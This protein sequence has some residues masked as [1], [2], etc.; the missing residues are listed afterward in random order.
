MRILRNGLAI[1]F[2]LLLVS[3]RP[4]VA[5]DV[6]ILSGQSNMQKIG[7]SA[8]RALERIAE[9]NDRSF[10]PIYVAAPG[11]P[12]EAWLDSKH[13]DHQ[14]WLSLVEQVNK[15]KSGDNEFKG[16]VWYQGESNVGR[17]AGKYQIQLDTLVKRVRH[18][19]GKPDL[20]AI[21]VQIG[22]ATSYSGKDWAAGT[23]REAQRRFARDDKRAAVVAAIDAEIGDYTVHLS[24]AGAELVSAR[25]AAA[26]DRLAYGN[27]SAFWGPQFKQAF[28]L[29]QRQFEVLVEFDNVRAEL[30]LGDGWLAGFGV[31]TKTSLPDTLAE[32]HDSEE[33]GQLVDDFLYPVGGTF[34][35]EHRLLLT[36]DKTLPADSRLSY[37]ASRNA[38]YGTQRR[39]GLEFGGLSDCSGHQAPA[40]VLAPIGAA[41]ASLKIPAGVLK[42]TKPVDWRQIAV[43]CV[44]RFP[45]AVTSPK[46][47]AGIKPDGWR[48]TYWNPASAGLVPNLFDKKGLVTPVTFHT[49]VWYMSPYFRELDNAD[50]ALMASW[51]KHSLH[52]WSGL[53]PQ[54]KYDLA[55]YL[56]Q[57]PPRRK[58]DNPPKHRQVRVSILH[59]PEGKKRKDAKAVTQRT[60]DVP[61]DGS[62]RGYQVAAESG[63]A[64]GNVILFTDIPADDRGR[65]ELA[66]EA[67]EKRGDKMRWSDTTLA[68]VQIRSK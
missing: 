46:D 16:F 39:W 38:Q 10:L 58:T 19:T 53:K 31:S 12:I 65:I 47:E 20:P 68:G 14:L 64:R 13:K 49:G 6:W 55:V 40:F 61:A 9:K 62:F 66:I 23:I 29:D 36:F 57:G 67:Y 21:I 44:G 17:N 5:A 18:L 52:A 63:D 33:L 3:S 34:I 60:L 4:L 54:H 28:F 24:K 15:A 50:D 35:D 27:Q 11:K 1:C 26:A 30:R 25:I 41:R 32:L 59:I 2:C 22:S 8:Q 51:C 43:N 56:L 45:A 48:Q 7:S 42:E 37:A